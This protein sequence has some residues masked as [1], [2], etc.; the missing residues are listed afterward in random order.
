[1]QHHETRQIPTSCILE[2]SHRLRE[3]IDEER[4]GA[5][6][7]SMAA[8][9]L[10][11]PIGVRGP[12]DGERFEIVW[13]HRRL[14]AAVLLRWPEIEAK[15]FPPDYDPLLAAVEENNVREAMTPMEDA[16]ALARFRERG[17]PLSAIARLWRRSAAWVG[18]RLALLELPRD[19][20]QAIDDQELTLSVARALGA[21]D[22][23]SYRQQLIDEAKRTGAKAGTVDIWVAHYRHDRE[24]IVQNH[25]TVEAIVANRE[26]WKLMVP[27]ELCQED[28]EYTKTRSLRCC[29]ECMDAVAVLIEEAAARAA[30]A[31]GL[32]TP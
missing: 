29:V 24:R 3:N 30:A 19:L 15:V 4:L 31:N 23:E 5:L 7:D 6:A 26:N 11:Q 10:H 32:P 18:E 21:I 22:H 14:L 8:S 1:M 28:Y 27:C 16:R 2:P 17:E 25:M 9:G 12:L 13:G 20:Q